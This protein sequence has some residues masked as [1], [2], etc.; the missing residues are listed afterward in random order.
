MTGLRNCRCGHERRAHEHYRRG[1]D[2]AIC[3]PGIC[4]RYRRTWGRLGL[5]L[6]RLTSRA[7]S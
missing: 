7:H 4:R 1:S 2:C 5:L 3:K 6:A